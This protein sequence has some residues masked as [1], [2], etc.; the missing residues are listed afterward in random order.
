MV[1][2][3]NIPI[4]KNMN[5]QEVEGLVSRLNTNKHQHGKENVHTRHFKK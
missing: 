4:K 3:N 1:L 5:Y 2:K